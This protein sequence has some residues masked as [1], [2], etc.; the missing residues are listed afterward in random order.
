MPTTYP[1]DRFDEW[2]SDLQRVGAHR[3]PAKANRRFVA[4][5]WAALVTGVL[6]AA[7]I[8]ALAKFSDAINIDLPFAGGISASESVTP[9]ASATAEPKIDPALPITILNG[10]TT[11]LLAKQVGDF[12]VTR[13]WDGAAEGVGS[14][15]SAS[16]NT[17][18]A[19]VVYY[20]DVANE[21]A[22]RAMVGTLG[23]GTISLGNTYPDSPLTVVIGSDFAL[24]AG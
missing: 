1:P 21:A 24:P 22:A 14:R 13:G 20:N 15:L 19:T 10:T 5:A 8:F 7:G 18:T 4:F 6:V 23:V 16:E 11:N 17:I 9:S 12:L 2:P 3:A